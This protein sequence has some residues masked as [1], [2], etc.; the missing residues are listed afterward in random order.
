VDADVAVVTV[1]AR[2]IGDHLGEVSVV[3]VL[4]IAPAAGEEPF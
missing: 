3:Q 1:T 2:D 4:R